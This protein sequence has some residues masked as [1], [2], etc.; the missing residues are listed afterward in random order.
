L[1]HVIVGKWFVSFPYL[2]R[3]EAWEMKEIGGNSQGSNGLSPAR[4]NGGDWQ[5]AE[6]QGF[7]AK[8]A[9]ILAMAG[10]AKVGATRTAAA[11]CAARMKRARAKLFSEV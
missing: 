7:S 9:R 8:A 11:A 2:G 6:G 3:W 5:E 4:A 1:T 10:S